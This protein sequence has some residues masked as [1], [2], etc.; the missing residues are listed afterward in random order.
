MSYW[1]K[2]MK[3]EIYRDAAGEWR[4]RLK[5]ANGRIIWMTSESY[6][7]RRDAVRAVE[8]LIDAGLKATV[9]VMDF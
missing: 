4:G 6:K 9:R 8:L 7:N 3:I 1:M 5:A 2:P